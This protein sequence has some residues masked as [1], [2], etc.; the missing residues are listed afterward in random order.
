MIIDLKRFIYLRRLFDPP[1]LLFILRWSCSLTFLLLLPLNEENLQYQDTWK[2][3][4]MMGGWNKADIRTRCS[5]ATKA[6]WLCSWAASHCILHQGERIPSQ[7]RQSGF[8]D[9]IILSVTWA[10]GW[11]EIWWHLPSPKLLPFLL[12]NPP[13][14]QSDYAPGQSNPTSSL[15]LS[16]TPSPKWSPNKDFKQNEFFKS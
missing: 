1:V 16:C 2:R 7:V 5:R 8:Q 11:I 14:R 12:S 10:V 13:N 6:C 4:D 3:W 9:V 15:S